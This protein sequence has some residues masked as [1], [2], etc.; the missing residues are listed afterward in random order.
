MA[1]TRCEVDGQALVLLGDFNP[2]IFQ[3]SW[4]AGHGLIRQEESDNADIAIIRPEISQFTVGSIKLLAQPNRFQLETLAI[5]DG[6]ALRDLALSVFRILEHTPLKALGINRDMHF[7]IESE[8]LWHAVGHRIVPK[9][10]W[11]DLLD[12][13]GTRSVTVESSR[14]RTEGRLTIKVEPSKETHPGVYIGTNLHYDK[15][16]PGV[17]ELLERIW[18]DSQLNARRVADTLLSKFLE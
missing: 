5:E 13:P 2:A 1:G 11:N 12:G 3:P 14:P 6:P 10:I 9:E 15:E 18:L 4:L 17:L 16:G 7:K 8:E